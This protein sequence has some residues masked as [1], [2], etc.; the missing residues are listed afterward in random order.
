MNHK[1]LCECGN[2]G[3]QTELDIFDNIEVNETMNEFNKETYK[4]RVYYTCPKCNTKIDF[5]L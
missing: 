1:V 2:C 3:T 4:I 5:T